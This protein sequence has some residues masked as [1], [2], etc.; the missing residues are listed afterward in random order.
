MQVSYRVIHRD[1][2]ISAHVASPQQLLQILLILAAQQIG[3]EIENLNARRYS[4]CGC[5]GLPGDSESQAWAF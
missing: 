5:V 1:P 4:Q 2:V 3:S